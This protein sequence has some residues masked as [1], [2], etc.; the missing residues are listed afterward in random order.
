MVCVSTS[1]VREEV[2]IAVL[3]SGRLLCSDA[4]VI[5]LF[6]LGEMVLVFLLKAAKIRKLV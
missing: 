3:F 5:N 6:F 4:N 2:K 1:R